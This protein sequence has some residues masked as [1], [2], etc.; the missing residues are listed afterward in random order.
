MGID[1]QRVAASGSTT[2]GLAAC[3]AGDWPSSPP[4]VRKA[5]K[6][7]V[8]VRRRYLISRDEPVIPTCC[9][10]FNLDDFPAYSVV[11]RVP[12]QPTD[13]RRDVIQPGCSQSLSTQKSKS[14]TWLGYTP[15]STLV[16]HPPRA[17][18][19]AR[20]HP[21][22][23]PSSTRPHHAHRPT[24][25]PGRDACPPCPSLNRAPIP[26]E[27]NFGDYQFDNNNLNACCRNCGSGSCSF[28]LY[29]NK[30]GAPSRG[31]GLPGP[32][33]RVE[34]DRLA[35]GQRGRRWDTRSAALLSAASSTTVLQAPADEPRDTEIATGG[36]EEE[37]TQ[38]DVLV[39]YLWFSLANRMQ[40]HLQTRRHP[41]QQRKTSRMN[42]MP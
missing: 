30:A 4:W 14:I 22:T 8:L 31:C 20:P 21:S 36:N 35:H 40:Q 23:P 13:E 1:G 37:N 32:R 9:G 28:P 26:A 27:H 25:W 29:V 3:L 39:S 5:K 11:G 41:V 12:S 10:T 6:N 16:I 18:L 38:S 33:R 2:A 7:P 19:F 42:W 15:P 17:T 24:G 34:T